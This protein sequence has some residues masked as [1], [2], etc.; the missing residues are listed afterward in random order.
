MLQRGAEVPE[1][2]ERAGQQ[3][4][5]DGRLERA[6]AVRRARH[7][8]RALREPQRQLVLAHRV[9]DQGDVTL[10]KHNINNDYY[11]II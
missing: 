3:M 8:Q 2:G 10:Y 6:R 9:Q 11:M 1:T 4:S 5:R 7:G